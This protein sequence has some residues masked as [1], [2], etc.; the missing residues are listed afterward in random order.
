M[1]KQFWVDM[2]NRFDVL[3]RFQK[4]PWRDEVLGRATSLPEDE[5]M[6]EWKAKGGGPR[7]I[8]ANAGNEDDEIVAEWRHKNGI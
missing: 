1:A 5:F 6:K 8:S 2:E 3:K 4:F 7:A